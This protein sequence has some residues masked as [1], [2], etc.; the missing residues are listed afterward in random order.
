MALSGETGDRKGIFVRERGRILDKKEKNM[1]INCEK[2]QNTMAFPERIWYNT[3][4]EGG[5]SP[6]ETDPRTKGADIYEVCVYG[7]KGDPSR[8]DP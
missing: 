5:P 3:D 7:Q 4:M 8:Q 6:S 1:K 2:I